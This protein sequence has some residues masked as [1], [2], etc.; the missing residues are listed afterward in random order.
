MEERESRTVKRRLSTAEEGIVYFIRQVGCSRIKV[1]TAHRERLQARLA[2]IQ[3][4]NPEQLE[5]L[6]ACPGGQPLEAEIHQQFAH[7]RSHGEWFNLAPELAIYLAAL[8]TRTKNA[9]TEWGFPA[10]VDQI[11]VLLKG[12]TVND[13][14]SWLEMEERRLQQEAQDFASMQLLLYYLASD[15]AVMAFIKGGPF[16]PS[17]PAR[18]IDDAIARAQMYRR[19]VEPPSAPSSETVILEP[20]YF[21][22]PAIKIALRIAETDSILPGLQLAWESVEKADGYLGWNDPNFIL[23]CKYCGEQFRRHWEDEVICLVSESDTEVRPGM[24]LRVECGQCRQVHTLR[25]IAKRAEQAAI[26]TT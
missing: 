26:P 13:L 18:G 25:R 5:L 6:L 17:V 21:R 8:A 11:A 14:F 3:R 7:L 20:Q 15:P 4:F 2:E 23:Q 19:T 12:I 1:G 10:V 16:S 22:L 9:G 24:P